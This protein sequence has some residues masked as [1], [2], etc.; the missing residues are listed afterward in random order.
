[1]DTGTSRSQK[2]AT[3]PDR[4][5]TIAFSP[6]GEKLALGFQ[7]RISLWRLLDGSNLYQCDTPDEIGNIVWTD[8]GTLVYATEVGTVGMLKPETCTFRQIFSFKLDRY[9]RPPAIADI[10]AKQG[11]IVANLQNQVQVWSESE[12]KEIFSADNADWPVFSDSDAVATLFD[13]LPGRRIVVGQ[14]GSGILRI[15]ELDTKNQ[16]WAFQADTN[17]CCMPVGMEVLPGADRLITLWSERGT[18]R[19]RTWRLLSTNEAA[20]QYAKSIIPE[21]LS[22]QS[23]KDLGVQPEPPPWCIE[24]EKRPYGSNAWKRWLKEK[25]TG[26]ISPSPAALI[27]EKTELKKLGSNRVRALDWNGAIA[28][29]RRY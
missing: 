13:V 12:A 23:R 5:S 25:M 2:S 29:T 8:D 27:D 1:L 14:A 21:C 16:V 3:L 7:K 20:T 18:F 28:V 4:I 26:N 15:Y 6:D 9:I 17:D 19:L 24:M 11:L 22:P 10:R